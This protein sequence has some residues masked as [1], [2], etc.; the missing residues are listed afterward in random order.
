MR[1]RGCIMANKAETP[2]EKFKRIA[3]ARTQKIIDMIE[4]LGNC[5]NT[6]VYEYSEEEVR[7]IFDA[8]DAELKITKEKYKG[9]GRSKEKF[10]L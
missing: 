8:I 5:S 10:T 4:L 3:T 9:N 1:G 2:N 6:Y 7:K